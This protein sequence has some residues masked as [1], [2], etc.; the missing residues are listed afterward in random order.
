MACGHV[1]GKHSLWRTRLIGTCLN[2]HVRGEKFS[3]LCHDTREKTK[4]KA[5]TSKRFLP[6]C[7]VGLDDTLLD[8]PILL[9]HDRNR[10]QSLDPFLRCLPNA[11][12]DTRCERNPQF[13]SE[14]QLSEA[15]GRFLARGM[16]MHLAYCHQA[17]THLLHHEAH[18]GIHVP[19]SLHFV[20][21][22]RS[23]VRVRQESMPKR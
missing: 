10:F 1:V 3:G 6:S 20:P 18:A 7:A 8:V 11:Q 14:S 19:E 21:G 13:S 4:I 15:Q 17:G 2:D 22:K 23:A 16:T 9:C 5:I 12:E